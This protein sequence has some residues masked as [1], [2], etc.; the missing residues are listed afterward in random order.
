MKSSSPSIRRIRNILKHAW[1]RVQPNGVAILA[2]LAGTFFVITLDGPSCLLRRTVGIP[3]PGCGMTR[4]TLAL[5]RLDFAA[6]FAYHPLVYIIVP[7][8]IVLSVLLITGRTT[9]KKSTPYLIA[10]MACLVIVYMV[11][12]VLLFPDAEPMT[13]DRD[14]LA[15]VLFRIIRV[16][17]DRMAGA[18]H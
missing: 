8:I 18:A 11:R 7:F 12:M 9:I 10:I 14:S 15:A 2:I 3:C 16:I 17:T 5:L 4:A 6:A 1:H 13:Y